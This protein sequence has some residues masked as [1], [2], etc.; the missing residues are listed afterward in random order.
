MKT[1]EVITKPW[2]K[3][4]SIR[5]EAKTEKLNQNRK[6]RDRKYQFSSNVLWELSAAHDS[7]LPY[8]YCR[9]FGVFLV[10]NLSASKWMG[11]SKWL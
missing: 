1:S 11:E 9:Q 8:Y 5:S 3:D 2:I 7:C 6:F 10:I 4:A